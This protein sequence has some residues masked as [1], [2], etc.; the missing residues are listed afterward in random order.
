MPSYDHGSTP[1]STNK[2]FPITTRMVLCMSDLVSQ[3]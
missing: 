2:V 1:P 3:F